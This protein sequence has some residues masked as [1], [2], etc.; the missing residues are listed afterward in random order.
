MVL[1]FSRK[2]MNK[3]PNASQNTEA[4][5]LLADVC[6]FGLFG[7]LLPAAVQLADCRFDSGVK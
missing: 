5:I 6:V 7:Q 1:P 3:I 2:S 4:K